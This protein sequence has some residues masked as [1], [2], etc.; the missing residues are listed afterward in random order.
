MVADGWIQVLEMKQEIGD[1]EYVTWIYWDDGS[2]RE[3]VYR[4]LQ[5]SGACGR[6][7]DFGNAR[8]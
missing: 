3:L 5:R 1:P 7:G 4:H 8:A 6:S 2:I